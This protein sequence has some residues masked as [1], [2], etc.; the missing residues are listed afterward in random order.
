MRITALRG[1]LA[2]IAQ[3][4]PQEARVLDLGCGDGA[5]LDWL[6]TEKGCHGYGAEIDHDHVRQCLRRG[7]NVIQADIDQGLT[8]FS[9]S[10]FDVVILSQALQATH[11]TEHVLQEMSRLGRDVIVSIPNFGHWSHIRSLLGGHMPVNERLP[12]A[13]YDT[14]NLHFATIRDFEALLLKLR[15]SILDRAYCVEQEHEIRRIDWAPTL[16]AT[17]ALYRF[18]AR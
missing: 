8:L 18:A 3:W 12:Y 2:Q 13:W 4:V 15:M 9:S 14:P 11:R 10:Q 5:L 7:V 17:L 1:D 16:R 6:Q